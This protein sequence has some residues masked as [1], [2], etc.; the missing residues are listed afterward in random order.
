M[1]ASFWRSRARWADLDQIGVP[2]ILGDAEVVI[3]LL[4]QGVSTYA[5]SGA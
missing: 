2:G 5:P 4:L 1:S 3:A